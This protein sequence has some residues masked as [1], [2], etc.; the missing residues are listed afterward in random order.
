MLR[1]VGIGC[2]QARGRGFI[3]QFLVIHAG[4]LDVDINA[5]E[6]GAADAFLVAHNGSCRT[7]AFPYRV[8]KLPTRA[9]V[10]IAVAH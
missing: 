7:R 4:N 8:P 3:S 9:P 5:V 10:R 6:Q 2:R 1:G